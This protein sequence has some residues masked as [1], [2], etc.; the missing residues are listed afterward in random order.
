M[1]HLREM[2]PVY[3]TDDQPTLVFGHIMAPHPPLFLDQD[4]NY[5]FEPELNG[6]TIDV[7]LGN[8]EQRKEAF[9]GQAECAVGFAIELLEALPPETIVVFAADHGSDS[10]NQLLTLA[11][12]WTAAG[13][14]ERMNVFLA[15]RTPENCALGSPVQVPNVMRRIL[16]CLGDEPAVDVEA[17]MFFGSTRPETGSP[18]LEP[19]DPEVVEALLGLDFTVAEALMGG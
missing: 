1:G 7:G 12:D 11:D 8:V 5:R 16:A 4:C 3:A 13:A 18:I 14:V 17:R 2:G 6:N 19:A 9:L 10:H 15:A